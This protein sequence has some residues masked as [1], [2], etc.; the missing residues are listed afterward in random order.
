MRY[1]RAKEASG[2]HEAYSAEDGTEE[3]AGSDEEEEGEDG[4]VAAEDV[5][6]GG[7]GGERSAR[8][9]MDRDEVK[10]RWKEWKG[11]M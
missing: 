8:Y 1:L 6:V 5:E 2:E 7:E 9:T 10:T 11:A 3:E 4:R